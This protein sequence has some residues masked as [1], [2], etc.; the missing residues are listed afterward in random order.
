MDMVDAEIRNILSKGNQMDSLDKINLDRLNIMKQDKE[1][2][3]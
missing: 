1:Q 2:N 3:F